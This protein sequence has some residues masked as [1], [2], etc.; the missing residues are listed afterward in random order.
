MSTPTNLIAVQSNVAA[1]LL[2]D[3]LFD[4]AVAR[5]GT[6]LPVPAERA[7]SQA[8]DVRVARLGYL[9]RVI[10]LERF[11]VARAPASWLV[12]RVVA[13]PEEPI[14]DLAAALAAEE[15]LEKS[16]PADGAPSWQIPGP[17]G[18]VRHFLALRAIDGVL[19]ERKRSWLFG[20]FVRC[21]EDAGDQPA[22]IGWP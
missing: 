18:H 3:G 10:E 16:A 15:P 7:L 5:V 13:R 2:I 1:S 20:F 14:A 9:A 4:E 19:S 8:D 21:C 17:G 11:E 12:E 22:S 6:A